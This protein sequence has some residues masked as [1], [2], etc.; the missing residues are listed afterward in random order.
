M[1]WYFYGFIYKLTCVSQPLPCRAEIS[2]AVDLV[3]F[4]IQFFLGAF[5]VAQW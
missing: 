3:L 1:I 4:H 2:D 5:Q